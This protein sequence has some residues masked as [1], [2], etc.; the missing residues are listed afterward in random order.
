MHD[1]ALISLVLRYPDADVLAQRDETRRRARALAPSPATAALV[2]FV[3][4][5]PRSRRT[6]WSA[7]MWRPSTSPAARRS[8]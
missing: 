7:G 8:I 5:W 2:D 3:D 1:L 6:P 4:W